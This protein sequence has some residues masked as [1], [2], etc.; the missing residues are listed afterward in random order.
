MSYPTKYAEAIL[1]LV[2]NAKFSTSGNDADTIQIVDW[3]SENPTQ[4][5]DA[6][7][8]TKI[9]ELETAATTAAT[10][11]A[12]A[13]ASGIAKLKAATWSPLTDDEADALFGE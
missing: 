7:I 5:T 2:P 8:K 10:N 6:A 9:T 3:D 13:K 12:N 11:K 4:P 1:A